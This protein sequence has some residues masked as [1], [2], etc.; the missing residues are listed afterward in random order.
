MGIAVDNELI[1]VEK[2]N[3]SRATEL[4]NH[5]AKIRSLG[6]RSLGFLPLHTPS[7]TFS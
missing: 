6:K 2:E 4:S 5:E 7:N 3:L 1:V